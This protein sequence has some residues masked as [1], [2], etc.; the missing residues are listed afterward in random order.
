[1]STCT[2]EYV[3]LSTA[4]Q[5]LANLKIV[6]H[7]IDPVTTYEILCNN[8]AAALVATNNLSQK[9]IQYLHCAFYF[10]NDFVQRK[11]V[12]LHWIP[13]TKQLANVFTKRLA[14]TKHCEAI[15][16][17]N[18]SDTPSEFFSSK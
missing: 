14:A 8:Q 9:K 12:K 11:Q 2:S 15:S 16:L 10:V 18:V 3:A 7:N 4:T 1:M 13:N 17:I 5:N 6:L